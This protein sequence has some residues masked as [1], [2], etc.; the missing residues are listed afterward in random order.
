ML[1]EKIALQLLASRLK[2]I[3]R[4]ERYPEAIQSEQFKNLIK[5]AKD[6]EWGRKYKYG[7]IR[8]YDDFVSRVPISDYEQIH[9][10][11]RRMME[12]EENI[13]WPEKVQWFAQSSGTTNDK[14]K[15]IPVTPSSLQKCH[16]RGGKDVVSTYLNNVPESRLFS[17]KA[18]VLGGS[19]K[20][21]AHNEFVKKGDLS[22]ILIQNI[23]PLANLYRTPS[24][25]IILMDEWEAK[26]EAICKHT[27]NKN[28]TSLSGVPSWL[29]VLIKKILEYTGKHHLTDIWPNLEVFFHGGV[30]FKPYEEQYKNLIPSSKMHY[31]ETYNASEGFFSLQND[32]NDPSMLL[33]LDY[34]IF[35]EFIPIEEL[36]SENPKTYPLESVETGRNYAVVMS[37]NNGLWRYKIGDTV[38]FTNKNPF[39]IV[40][41]GRT[42][43]FINAFGEELMVDNAE[44]A[45]LKACEKTGSIVREYTV[46]PVYMSEEMKGRH[47]WLIEFTTLPLS[48]ED[49]ALQLDNALKELNSDYEAKRY[50][51]IT[52]EMPEITISKPNLFYKWLESKGKLGGQHKIPRLSNNREIMDSLQHFASGKDFF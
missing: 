28:V 11:I 3:A 33:L 44:R 37:S 25:K 19:H 17:G 24:K 34:G 12:G 14:S 39:K 16:Y 42:R 48:L 36:Q 23:N 8:N 51:N 49:F 27:V 13:L 40:V 32:F 18:L 6:T 50:K 52:L 30:S 7:E 46:A 41:T 38:M 35:Y 26:L 20:P 43:N 29:L 45:I 1:P 2:S 9:P 5:T 21:V 22:A 15:F 4:F 31:L 10:Y 47:Q